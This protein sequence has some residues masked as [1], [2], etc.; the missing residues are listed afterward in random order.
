M[1]GTTASSLARREGF[2]WHSMENGQ[3]L[4]PLHGDFSAD[5]L[6]I[7]FFFVKRMTRQY[8][9][10]ILNILILEKITPTASYQRTINIAVL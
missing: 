6:N 1:I 3:I 5:E 9:K 4:A 7:F 2:T 8:C 10:P